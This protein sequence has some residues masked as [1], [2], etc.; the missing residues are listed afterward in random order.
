M[1]ALLLILAVFEAVTI[2]PAVPN[3]VGSSGED[4]RNGFLKVYNVT[5]KRCIRYAYR[6]PETQIVGGPKWVDEVRYDIN[7]K[8]AEPIAEPELLTMLQPV[9]AN[10]FMLRLH[11][12]TRM[13][14]GYA[15][16]IAKSGIKAPVS[17]PNRR[18]GADGGRGRID[19]VATP[20]GELLIRLSELLERPVAD[21]TQDTRR[22]DFHL[23]WTP[24][25]AA[26]GG[27]VSVSAGPSIFTA[28]EEQLGLKL[29]AQKV[30]AEVLVVD[31]AELPTDN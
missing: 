3:A 17:D 2:K 25:T 4:G 31:H 28:L 29:V 27:E 22:F 15:L 13:M 18:S 14:D 12:E 10:R 19:T 23:R 21:M 30:P 1:K 8:A 20:M 9:L 5:L 16:T 24:D 11:R 7:A 26:A 6:M